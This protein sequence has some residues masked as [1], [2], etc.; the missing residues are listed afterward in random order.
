MG[1]E[2]SDINND[3]LMEIIVVGMYAVTVFSPD[4]QAA[5]RKLEDV[6]KYLEFSSI[7]A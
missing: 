1:I 4:I 5:L 6:R 7:S 3:G 2:A